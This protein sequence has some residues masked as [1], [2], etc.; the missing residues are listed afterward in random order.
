MDVL[1]DAEVGVLRSGRHLLVVS[2]ENI[3]HQLKER[4]SKVTDKLDT[5]VLISLVKE[6]QEDCE[7]T[8]ATRSPH[9]HCIAH[10]HLVCCRVL[11]C[12]CCL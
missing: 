1:T 10:E 8:R 4:S 12:V 7:N 11:V 3:E 2:G 5:R 9:A 6:V